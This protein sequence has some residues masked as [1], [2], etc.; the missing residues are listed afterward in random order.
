M[1]LRAESKKLQLVG[2]SRE[3]VVESNALLEFSGE[4]FFDFND[5]LAAGTDQVVMV[6]LAARAD[7]LKPS[8]SIT[9][10]E[11]LHDSHVLQQMHTA[12]NRRQ[13]AIASWQ[14]RIDGFDGQRSP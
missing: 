12:V 14:R 8:N 6:F 7:Q 3:A 13:I 4:T 1:A 2:D 10:I 5:L 11:S 9:Q